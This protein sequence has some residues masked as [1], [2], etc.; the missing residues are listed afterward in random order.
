V[1]K[2][3]ILIA[4]LAVA[5]CG[6]KSEVQSRA[7]AEPE[8]T[9]T[10]TPEPIAVEPTPEPEPEP[11]AV[12]PELKPEPDTV[13]VPPEPEPEPASKPKP[14]PNKKRACKA[15]AEHCCLP[16]GKIVKPGGCQ[17]M[18]PDGVRPAT[19]RG[20]GGWCE[21]ISCN[22]R[23][24]PTSARI[25]TPRGEVP[26][27]ELR[28]GDEVWTVDATGARV[29]AP[30]VRI[31]S[32]PVPDSHELV[33]LTLTDGRRVRASAGHPTADGKAIGALR[34]GDGLDGSTVAA[35]R[36]LPYDGEATWD[37]LPAGDTGA[38]WADGVLLGSTLE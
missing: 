7:P 26:V 34:A 5:G 20:A 29:A 30:I 8:P 13:G 1:A 33:E 36:T 27:T 25:A 18:Y 19:V 10:P 21:S 31:G 3:A 12:E 16:D 24:L 2:T 14:N 15:D 6:G 38:Y 23:C 17:P 28:A 4:V 22:L 37:L 9:A 11:P 35:R 32:S